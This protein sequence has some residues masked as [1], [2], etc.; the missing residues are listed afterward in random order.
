M[1]GDYSLQGKDGRYRDYLKEIEGILD[2]LNRKERLQ[3]VLMLPL[4]EM[5]KRKELLADLLKAFSV[6]PPSSQIL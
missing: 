2:F 3:R 4:I 5:E 1:Q 6:S